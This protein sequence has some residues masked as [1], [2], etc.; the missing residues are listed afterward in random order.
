MLQMAWWGCLTIMGAARD[1]FVFQHW[2][3]NK[4]LQ[5]PGNWMDVEAESVGVQDMGSL[6]NDTIR[7]RAWICTRTSLPLVLRYRCDQD[8]QNQTSEGGVTGDDQTSYS[9]THPAGTSGYYPV[10]TTGAAVVTATYSA[11]K[12]RYHGWTGQVTG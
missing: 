11:T 9:Y 6:R 10:P 7:F 4:P 3:S 12:N 5:R 1:D 2:Q 8:S